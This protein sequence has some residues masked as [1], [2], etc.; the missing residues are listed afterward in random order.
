[1]KLGRWFRFSRAYRNCASDHGILCLALCYIGMT[2]K[3][4][5]TWADSPFAGAAAIAEDAAAGDADGEGG[6]DGDAD[7]VADPPAAADTRAV[8]T[9]S[10]NVERKVNRASALKLCSKIL[11]KRQ[12]L[13]LFDYVTCVL[14][15]LETE[16][17][18]VVSAHKTQ[19][20]SL[21]WHID[22]RFAKQAP[23][24]NCAACRRS[25]C[26]YAKWAGESGCRGCSTLLS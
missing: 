4:W 7:D 17:S 14:Q 19:D 24:G 11:G 23:V 1:M 13:S 12:T 5:R 2:R 18:E 16:H 10:L 21:Y 3:W 8:V 25:R 26:A 20:G 22:C 15:P 6:D 9:S